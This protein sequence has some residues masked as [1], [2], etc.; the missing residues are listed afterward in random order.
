[1][2]AAAMWESRDLE[3]PSMWD[4]AGHMWKTSY[5]RLAVAAIETVRRFDDQCGSADGGEHKLADK[6][7]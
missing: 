7:A 3:E 4:N 1:M 5:R 6:P 2:V